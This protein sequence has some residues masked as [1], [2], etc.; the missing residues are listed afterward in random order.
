[1]DIAGFH[2]LLQNESTLVSTHTAVIQATSQAIQAHGGLS[3]PFAGD[4]VLAF[5]NI[6]N[7][8]SDHAARC[9][10]AAQELQQA[11]HKLG[12]VVRLACTGGPTT[13]GSMGTKTQRAF[14]VMGPCVP[15]GLVL[16]KLAK[17][18][19]FGILVDHAIYSQI[20]I[21][22][23]CRLALVLPLGEGKVEQAY[24]V[25]GG[26]QQADDEWMYQLKEKVLFCK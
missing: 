25:I 20:N 15:R 6:R 11:T 5:W 2:M 13:F 19:P 24:E 1:M 22:T 3:T 7:L 12:L 23:Q 4:K 17:L 9:V 14:T 18:I 26:L 10:A 16:Q 8:H 21:S